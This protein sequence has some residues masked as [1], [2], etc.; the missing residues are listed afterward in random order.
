MLFIYFVLQSG[1]ADD[2]IVIDESTKLCAP[3]ENICFGRL[4]VTTVDMVLK[5]INIFFIW[6]VKTARIKFVKKEGLQ[7]PNHK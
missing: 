5:K 1:S 7:I 2:D 6:I 3:N 4:T